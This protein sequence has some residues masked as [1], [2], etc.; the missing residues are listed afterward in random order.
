MII[1]KRRVNIGRSQK[2][3]LILLL[4]FITIPILG[5][6]AA[7]YDPS[8]EFI[9]ELA[10]VDRHYVREHGKSASAVK[11]EEYKAYFDGDVADCPVV[12]ISNL[13]RRARIIFFAECVNINVDFLYDQ[14]VPEGVLP[15]ADAIDND[16][17]EDGGALYG[18]FGK[19][20]HRTFKYKSKKDLKI[21]FGSKLTAT[22]SFQPLRSQHGNLFI[23]FT[24]PAEVPTQYTTP[25][26]DGLVDRFVD[27]DR[28]NKA[29][30]LLKDETSFPITKIRTRKIF[31]EGYVE[32]SSAYLNALSLLFEMESSRRYLSH[33][34]EKDEGLYNFPFASLLVLAENFDEFLS[35]VMGDVDSREDNLKMLIKN[36]FDLRGKLASVLGGEDE[37]GS[38]DESDSDSDSDSEDE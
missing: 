34:G 5:M 33:R 37:S 7:A 38:E 11:I 25:A 20:P 15:H 27:E 26:F 36:H 24:T 28:K 3:V 13:S 17:Y 21:K 4:S 12:D 35:C 32:H 16:I 10:K 23:N 31:K 29:F 9:T 19:H 22:I 8:D 1:F 6:C 18:M 30:L 2:T 14:I